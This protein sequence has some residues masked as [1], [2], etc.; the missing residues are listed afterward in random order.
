MSRAPSPEVHMTADE[1]EAFI[2][3]HLQDFHAEIGRIASVWAM[4]EFRMDQLIWHLA[5]LEQTT[6]ACLTTQ[7]NGTTPRLRALKALLELR[8][9]APELLKQLNKFTGDIVA[10]QE[11]RNRAVHDPWFVGKETKRVSQIRK[12]VIGNRTIY[13]RL[14]VQLD[15]LKATYVAS[16]T[17]LVTFN[18]LRNQILAEPQDSLRERRRTQR[19]HSGLR[20]GAISNQGNGH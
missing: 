3:E 5:G 7:M 2:N 20:G 15:E 18:A 13:E 11:D 6:G 12:A 14:P 19:W 17:V 16:K 8:G 1:V 10:P 9:S 4:L